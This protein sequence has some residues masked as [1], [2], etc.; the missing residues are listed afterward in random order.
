LAHVQISYARRAADRSGLSTQIHRCLAGLFSTAGSPEQYLEMQEQDHP[1]M[2][3]ARRILDRAGTWEAVRE[4]LLRV[5]RDRNE[6]PA[7][8]RTTSRY[9]VI[10][11]R[12]AAVAGAR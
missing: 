2:I 3:G 5:V 6:E 7:A 4:E 1:L 8:F 12:S 9:L 10:E 11:V